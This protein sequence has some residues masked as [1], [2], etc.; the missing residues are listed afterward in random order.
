MPVVSDAVG[1]VPKSLERETEKVVN[2]RINQNNLDD[3]ILDIGQN[4][5]ESRT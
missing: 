3:S 2:Q 5:E 1:T 4:R